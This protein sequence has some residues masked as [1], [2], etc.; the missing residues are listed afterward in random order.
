MS[1]ELQGE[2]D[3]ITYINEEGLFTIA[4]LRVNGRNGI[5]MS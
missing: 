1:T 5:V 4:K 2:I 3:R